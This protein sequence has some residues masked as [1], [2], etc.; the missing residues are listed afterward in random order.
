M[1]E[2]TVEVRVTMPA[3][4]WAQVCQHAELDQVPTNDLLIGAIK[5]F[6]HHKTVNAT[7]ADLLEHE[8]EEWLI[9]EDRT[10]DIDS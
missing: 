9:D 2:E 3:D 10:A 5:Q 1:P 7:L 4:L 8:Y 6:L